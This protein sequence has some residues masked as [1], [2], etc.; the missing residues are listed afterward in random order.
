MKR[1]T[2]LIAL[3]SIVPALATDLQA[4]GGRALLVGGSVRDALLGLESKDFDLEVFGLEAESLENCLRR[5]VRLDLVGKAFGVYKVKGA[6][7]D[8]SLPRRESKQGHGH[9]GFRIEGDPG[10]EF[11]AAAARRDFT[12]NAIGWDPLT[13]EIIDPHGGCKDLKKGILRHTSDQFAEDPLRV[14]RAMQFIARFDL[15]IAP[16]TLALCRTIEPENLPKERLFEEWKKWLLKG[17]VP[18]KG[19]HFLRDSGWLKYYP[20]LEAMVGCPQDSTWHPEGDVWTHTLHCIDAFARQ[21]TGQEWEDLVVGFAVLLHDV[22]KPL[23]TQEGEDGRI[24]SPRHD[25]AGVGPARSFIQRLSAQ[26]ALLEE[27]LV[28]VETHMRPAEFYK[29]QAGP[30]AIR[31][32][33]G[34]VGRIDRLVRVAEADMAGRPPLAD[35]FPAGKWLRAQ[36]EQLRLQDKR[37]R[38]ILKGRHL[39][40][41]GLKPGPEFS[42]I[43]KACFEAQLD[44][45]F[46]D[47][48][49]ALNFLKEKLN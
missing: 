19:L 43:L 39:I 48:A 49:G 6:P 32:L 31:R 5:K 23:T 26:K 24:R 16:E 30:G 2:D 15:V 11:A 33:A 41:Q 20:E 25:I 27:I 10:L 9:K 34:K 35:D 21:K 36:A 42:A 37:P 22:G 40:A 45:E 38:P 3:P 46:E 47:E 17:K 4:A 1:I 13:G 14:L 29:T 18:S 7:I 44:G 28:L 12:L 8:I